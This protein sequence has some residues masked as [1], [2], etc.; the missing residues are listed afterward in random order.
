MKKAA[1]FDID[2]LAEL[3]RLE[4]SREEKAHFARQLPAIVAYVGQLQGLSLEGVEETAQVTGL[5]NILR[6]DRFVEVADA[7]RRAARDALLAAAPAVQ[8]HLVKVPAILH[9]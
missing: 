1:A 4:L 6:E 5:E 2:H 7:D 8:D 3:A 9:E